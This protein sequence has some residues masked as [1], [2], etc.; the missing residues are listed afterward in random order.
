MFNPSPVLYLFSY[1]GST[2]SPLTGKRGKGCFVHYLQGKKEG[3]MDVRETREISKTRENR[4]HASRRDFLKGAAL[5]GAGALSAGVL[6]GCSPDTSGDDAA[7]GDAAGG[8]NVSGGVSSVTGTLPDRAGSYAGGGETAASSPAPTWLGESPAVPSDFKEEKEA[9]VIVVG[10]GHAGLACG[11][12][13]AEGGRS[14]IILEA[15]TQETMTVLGNDIGH[16]NSQWQKSFGVPEYDVMEFLTCYQA[17]CANRAHPDLIKQYATRSGEA[18]DWFI[19]ASGSD[20]GSKINIMNWPV[21]NGYHYKQGLYTTYP[22]QPTFSNEELS[23]SKAHE[24]SREAFLSA[25]GT[26]D[27]GVT[28]YVLIKEGDAVTGVVG[29]TEDGFIKYKASL[30]VVLAGGDFSTNSPMFA[31]LCRE[32]AETSSD[33]VMGGMMPMGRDGSTIKLG[34]WAGGVMEVGPRAA[35]GGAASSP[36]GPLSGAETL[37]LNKNG[38]RF[39]NE[40]FGGPFVSGPQGARQPKGNLYTIFDS[41]WKQVWFN[42]PAAHFADKDWSP[43]AEEALEANLQNVVNAGSTGAAVGMAAAWASDSLEELVGYLGLSGVA[44]QNAVAAVKRYNELAQKGVDED[45]GKPTELMFPINTPPYFGFAG[46]RN[47]NLVLVTLAGLFIDKHHQVVDW[48]FNPIKGLYATGNSSGGRF[49]LQYTSPL[50]GISIGI[51]LTLGYVLGEHL[52]TADLAAID[53]LN[54]YHPTDPVL[55]ADA[56]PPLGS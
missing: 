46:A 16:L 52:A 20:A 32:A 27:Y 38:E 8:G 47:A 9:E 37:W 21:V 42:Q 23:L 39:C 29:Q 28:G 34:L 51:A 22:G 13:A 54:A 53:S 5:L 44:A 36:M 17:S 35:M 40:G 33:Q 41:N 4:E 43:A 50:N 31:D 14:V 55:P 25:G 3:T 45:Y 10:C 19:A 11:R 2:Y 18:F 30:G 7:G 15:G 26:I 56:Q 6:A 1:K 48:D 24:N 49:P 12:K